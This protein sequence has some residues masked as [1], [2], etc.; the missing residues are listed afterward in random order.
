[1]PE[2]SII[3]VHHQTPELLKLCLKSL[4]KTLGSEAQPRGPLEVGPLSNCEIVVVDS[5]VSRKAR[6]LIQEINEVTRPDLKEAP[7]VGPLIKYLPFKENLG[8]A[9]GVNVGIKNSS[10]KYILIL[11]P[12]VIVTDGTINK[13]VKYMKAHPDIGI[14][15]PRVLNFNGTHQKTYFSYYKPV[16]IIARRSFLSRFKPFR[17]VLNDFLMV[18]TDPTKIQTPDWLMGSAIMVSREAINKV[19]TMDKRFFM[20]FE[21]VDW[22]RRFWHN[23]YKVVYYPEAIMYHY[24]QRESVS[25]LGLLDAIFNH[26]TRWHIKSAIKFFWKYRDLSKILT[27]K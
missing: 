24:H 11:N 3:I 10:G 4:K 26:K 1:M 14:L 19:G 20:Y 22:A 12:D 13:M 15:G 21:D 16:T 27:Y 7:M 8:Y 17:R 6:D 25:G 18:D 2:L 5:T 23:D 9:R